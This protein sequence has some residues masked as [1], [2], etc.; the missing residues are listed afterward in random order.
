MFSDNH[1]PRLHHYVA[2][3]LCRGLTIVHMCFM[4][5]AS[6]EKCKRFLYRMRSRTS[7]LDSVGRLED[8]ESVIAVAVIIDI[9][10]DDRSV[11]NGI[12]G[13]LQYLKLL[14]QKLHP[15]RHRWGSTALR[16]ATH[17]EPRCAKDKDGLVFKRDPKVH[18]HRRGKHLAGCR[19]Q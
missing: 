11:R 16:S 15:H 1:N 3:I 17:G 8:E 9:S 13:S 2:E 4:C 19:S 12:S 7:R 10:P 5:L 14:A 6:L 18:R